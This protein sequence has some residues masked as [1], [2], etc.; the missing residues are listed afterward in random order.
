MRNTTATGLDWISRCVVI[1][2]CGLT[3]FHAQ[4]ID[5]VWSGTAG[6]LN[7]STTNNWTGGVLPG[8]NDRA[9]FNAAQIA[10]QTVTLG[11]NQVVDSLILA[12][13]VGSFTINGNSQW[14]L[15]LKS[16]KIENGGN[17]YCEN[18]PAKPLF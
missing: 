10:N 3:T 14:S 2:L 18:K 7:W 16:G 15:T 1:A 6:D 4:A 17:T 5:V 13:S 9:R 8:E 12:G 11:T